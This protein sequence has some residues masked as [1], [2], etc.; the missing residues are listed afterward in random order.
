MLSLPTSRKYWLAGTILKKVFFKWYPTLRKEERN[1]MPKKSA[2]KEAYRSNNLKT[3]AATF[4]W[5]EQ[6]SATTSSVYSP[7]FLFLISLDNKNRLVC[8]SVFETLLYILNATSGFASSKNTRIQINIFTDLKKYI[9]NYFTANR[10][11]IS[12]LIC[13]I[14]AG[15]AIV[16][17]AKYK[18]FWKYVAK[19]YSAHNTSSKLI[20]P[21]LIS[22][23]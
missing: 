8:L 12:I 21:P 15:N 19:L 16:A 18:K 5:K 7:S 13:L 2:I 1:P 20:L 11:Q 23:P 9:S 14:Y 4:C 17:I 10:I 3:G 22:A 6:V